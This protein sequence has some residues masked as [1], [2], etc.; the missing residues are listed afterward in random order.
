MRKRVAVFFIAVLILCLIPTQ[1]FA[2]GINQQNVNS[3][4]SPMWVSIIDFQNTFDPSVS[5]AIVNSRLNARSNINQ[6][7]ITASIQQLTNGN[8]V[9]IKTWTSTSY[10]NS[11]YLDQVWYLASGYAYRMVTTGA[12]YQNGSF[13]EQASYTSPTYWH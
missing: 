3:V 11:G 1:I 9:T 7:V 6:V 12:V 5:P 8:W 4:N 13:V 2:Q 10:S